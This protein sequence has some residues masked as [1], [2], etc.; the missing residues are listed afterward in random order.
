MAADAVDNQSADRVIQGLWIGPEL[1]TMERLAVASF[2]ANGHEF[3]LYVYSHVENV[4]S[5]TVLR[6]AED[7]LPASSIFRYRDNG[8]YAGFANFF[9]YELLWKY[10]GW[11]VDLDTVCLSPFRFADDYVIGSEPLADGGSQ[12]INGVLKMPPQSSLMQYLTETCR[13]KNPDS[14][15]WGETG[16]NLVADGIRRLSLENYV[17]AADAF[18]PFGWYEWD[19]AL[20]P[21]FSLCSRMPARAVHLWNEVWRRNGKDKDAVYHPDCLYERLKAKYL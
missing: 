2:L 6:D 15:R 8:S 19:K 13:G 14:L 1:S 16:P 20:D 18:C 9:R 10:G 5:G 17:Q 21:M 7:I 3:H 11:W 4:P 12:P